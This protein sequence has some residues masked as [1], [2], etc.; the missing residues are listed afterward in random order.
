MSDNIPID[1]IN[2][3]ES[4]SCQAHVGSMA[5]YYKKYNKSI[6]D[7]DDFWSEMAQKFHWYKKWD[8]VRTF[9]YDMREGPVNVNW[10]NGAKTNVCY[11]CVDRH[12]EVR[13]NKT[14]L[15]WASNT[16]YPNRLWMR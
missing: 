4:V 16:G 12:L 13:P 8:N 2:V 11:N 6:E 5:E 3:P 14:A 15:I 9:N 1:L 10:Y 7:P